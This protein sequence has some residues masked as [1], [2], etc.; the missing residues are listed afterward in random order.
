MIHNGTSPHVSPSNALLSPEVENVESQELTHED[1]WD[2]SA[3]IAAWNAATEEYE[4]YNGP[5]KGWKM[6]PVHKS[7]LWYN[8][9]PSPTKTGSKTNLT[10]DLITM[11]KNIQGN[12]DQEDS[13]PLDFDTFVPSHN[14]A[15]DPPL[16][17]HPSS[18]PVPDYRSQFLPGPGLVDQ[19]EAFTRALGAMYWGGYWTAVY[20]CQKSKA[21]KR[22]LD[23]DFADHDSDEAD[24]A[25]EQ[26]SDEEDEDA[27]T[28]F[29]STQ[30]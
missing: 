9:P 1:V 2:D 22:P 25:T 20:H 10:E 8:V 15:L 14:P 6:E 18:T 28:G 26:A 17:S 7:P 11:P 30:R 21:H 13:T 19:D 27:A 4:A 24:E 5:E 16:H 3:L 29:V 12:N 23:G